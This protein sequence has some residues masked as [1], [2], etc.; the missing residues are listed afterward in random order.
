M[1]AENHYSILQQKEKIMR[2]RLSELKRIAVAF[3][4]GVDSSVLLKTAA[5]ELG[6]NNV[7]AITA[8]GPFYTKN[9]QAR[10]REIPQKMG[11][12]SQTVALDFLLQKEEFVA[13]NELRCYY[14]KK[15]LWQKAHKILPQNYILVDGTNADDLKEERTG[16]IA[17][18]EL[19]LISP[20]A[21]AGF[22]KREVRALASAFGFSFWNEPASAC[23]ATRF[24]VGYPIT[25]EGLKKIETAEEILHAAGYKKVRVRLQGDLARIEINPFFMASFVKKTNLAEVVEKIKKAGFRYV[26]LDL[27][28]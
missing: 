11:I 28:R 25:L 10:A 23:L 14:C 26:T 9:E 15:N 7:L 6:E 16:L 4:G 13:N 2:R 27:G 5:A 12:S 3:S 1:Q 19:G 21:E 20:L 18:K 8:T 24:P 22:S 17:N